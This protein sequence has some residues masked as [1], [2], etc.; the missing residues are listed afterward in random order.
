MQIEHI[1]KLYQ[2]SA[3][4]STDTRTLKK[5]EIFWALSGNNFDGSRFIEKAFK[6]GAD[7]CITEN[8]AFQNKSKCIYT[9]NSLK[10]LQELANYHRKK[11]KAKI[12]AITGTNGKT[13]SKEL[14]AAVLSTQYNTQ[15][16]QGNYNNHI[17]VPLT[18]LSFNKDTEFGIVETGANHPGEI[19]FLCHIAEPDYGIITNIGK[20]HLE[21]YGSFQDLINTKKELYDFLQKDGTIF[22]N[23]DN[24]LLKS[25][26]NKHKTVSYGSNKEADF[27]TQFISAEPFLKMKIRYGKEYGINTKITGFYNFENVSAAACV[28]NFFNIRPENIKKAVENYIPENNRSQYIKI[29][30]SAIISDAYN[31][32]PVSMEKALENFSL[33]KAKKK[34]I[35]IGDMFELGKYAETEHENI[36]QS[37]AKLFNK[38][39]LIFTAGEE[40]YKAVKKTKSVSYITAFQTR[41][42]LCNYI[43]DK[44]FENV[45]VLLKGSRG[46]KMETLVKYLNLI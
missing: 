35:I 5:G 12:I 30:N 20:A 45:S 1:Y 43:K 3:G 7:Y 38:N 25:L 22:I 39:T 6:L 29:G 44:H 4:I 11:L 8:P 9:D 32:N 17:G 23:N 34:I 37:L 13:T 10:T 31:A 16:T 40:F 21:G 19:K 26:I 14:I 2:K 24:E 15:A 27:C 18:L 41:E 46:M 28:G 42:E 36:I 33:L